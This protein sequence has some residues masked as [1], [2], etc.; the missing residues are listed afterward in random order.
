MRKGRKDR[1][2]PDEQTEGLPRKAGET[3]LKNGDLCGWVIEQSKPC[4]A[5]LVV[6]NSLFTAFDGTP[7]YS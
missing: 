6:P 1:K 7:M 4:Q 5:Q 2:L 3:R